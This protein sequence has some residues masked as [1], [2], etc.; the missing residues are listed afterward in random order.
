MS[1]REEEEG[2]WGY[3]DDDEDSINNQNNTGNGTTAAVDEDEN[4]MWSLRLRLSGGL[5][6]HLTR[7][8]M[9]WSSNQYIRG[10]K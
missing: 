7:N 2:E 8:M 5:L 4:D 10:S 6:M 3:D 1:G 9:S